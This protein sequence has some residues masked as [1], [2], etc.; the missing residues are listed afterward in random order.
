MGKSLTE[1][2][3]AILMKEDSAVGGYPSVTPDQFGSFDRDAKNI[4]PNKATL[5]PG[6]RYMDAKPIVN[7]GSTPPNAGDYQDLGPAPV[8]ATDVPGS[9]KAAG[10]VKKDT[11]KSGAAAVPAEKASK[12]ANLEEDNEL[13]EEL[14]AFI[15]E[16]IEQGLSEEEILQAIEENFEFIEEESHCDKEDE[17]EDEDEDKEKKKA[18]HKQ[19]MKEHVDA[20]L[21]GE[22]L[23]EEFRSKAETIFESAVSTRVNEELEMLEEAYVNA[24]TE[25]VEKITEQLTEQVDDYLN[26]VIEQW[27]AENEVAIEA[28]LRTEITEDFISGLRSLFAEHYIDVPEEKVQVVEQFGSKIEELEAKLNEEIARNVELTKTLNESKKFEVYVNACDGLT[29]T[30]A[31]KLRALAENVEFTSEDEFSRKLQTLKESYFPSTGVNTD[32][33]LDTVENDGGMLTEQTSGRMGAYVKA[34]G[35]TLP[36]K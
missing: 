28:G 21:A 7:P 26:Y 8:N 14:D 25:E 34:I 31:E 24:L 18:K 2:A 22:N 12:P 4:T 36:K 16:M 27:V 15:N 10:T 23:S 19:E 5:R 20:L 29:I 9:A 32:N 35:K 33:V 17:G 13:S 6:S 1:T 30:Q 3:K 11:S